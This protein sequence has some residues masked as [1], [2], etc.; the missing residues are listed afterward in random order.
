MRVRML[1]HLELADAAPVWW[2][3]SEDLPGLTVAA[4]DLAEL[5]RLIREQ[6]AEL[7]PEIV[8]YSEQLVG[9][10]SEQGPVQGGE[11]GCADSPRSV[12]TVSKQ[13]IAA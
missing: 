3:E 6:L 1:L 11:V 8:Q 7:F 12:V 13:L 10:R 5:R 9:D 4:D 2:A